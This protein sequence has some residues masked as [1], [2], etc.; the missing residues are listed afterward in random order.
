MVTPGAVFTAANPSG[1]VTLS[2]SLRY[3]GTG[4]SST[5]KA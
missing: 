4:A 1:A 2:L 3:E 5:C